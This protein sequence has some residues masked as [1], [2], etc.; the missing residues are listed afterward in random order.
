MSGIE[1]QAEQTVAKPLAGR[2]AV[3]TGASSGIG[4]AIARRLSEGGASVALLARRADRLRNVADSLVQDGGSAIAVTA[5]V[6]DLEAV[7][8]AVDSVERELG[9]PDLLVSC[10][11]LA[12]PAPFDQ[13]PLADVE[14]MVGTNVNGNL[15]LIRAFMPHLLRSA[16]SGRPADVAIIS[17]TSARHRYPAYVVYCATKAAVSALAEG[18]R[19]EYTARG[20]RITNVEPGLADTDMH[21]LITDPKIAAYVQ[22]LFSGGPTLTADDVAETVAYAV[23]LPKHL[24]MSHV[25][26]QAT[27]QP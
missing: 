20:V 21:R 12:V 7:E 9:S 4:A 17:S 22:D 3:V 23:S 19:V 26:I 2:I 11:G 24:N 8:A 6:T 16:E 14:A 13:Q 27:A 5:D 15:H 25:V 18:L 10:A 1:A